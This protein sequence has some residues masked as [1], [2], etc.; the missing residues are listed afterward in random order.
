MRDSGDKE[1]ALKELEFQRLT[2][3][4]RLRSLFSHARGQLTEMMRSI[5]LYVTCDGNNPAYA[6]L[7]DEVH[8]AM[9]YNLK[10]CYSPAQAGFQSLISNDKYI[11]AVLSDSKQS[12]AILFDIDKILDQDQLD[13]VEEEVAA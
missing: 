4:K 11:K 12:K 9:T 7:I 13:A 1:A 6:L 3:L 2:T 10:D 8:D 5:L